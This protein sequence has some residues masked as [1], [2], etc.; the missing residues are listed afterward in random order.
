MVR[1]APVL[2]ETPKF[3]HHQGPGNLPGLGEA[4]LDA[5]QGGAGSDQQRL[6]SD[7]WKDGRQA[8]GKTER[9]SDGPAKAHKGWPERERW[10]L[11]RYRPGL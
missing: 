10:G 8:K 7:D 6:E 1:Q 4:R 2:L 3:I 11:E 9:Q 5:G